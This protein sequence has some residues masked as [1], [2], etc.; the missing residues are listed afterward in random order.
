MEQL[1]VQFS[2]IIDSPTLLTGCFVIISLILAKVS[3]FIFSFLVRKIVV[4]TNS[5]IDDQ[6]VGYLHKPIYYSILFVGLTITMQTINKVPENIQYILMGIF[7][8]IAIAIW[9]FAL[10][11]IFMSQFVLT[12][13]VSR[14]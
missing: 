5:N 6:I 2:E 4:K 14:Q 10:F 8:S 12:Y 3:D 9:S 1:I 11:N 7:K 13:Q